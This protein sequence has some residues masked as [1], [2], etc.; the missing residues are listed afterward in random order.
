MLRVLL[1]TTL[2]SPFSLHMLL[3]TTFLLPFAGGV[4]SGRREMGMLFRHW[5]YMGTCFQAP[6][7]TPGQRQMETLSWADLMGCS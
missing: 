6:H 2:T 7:A 3:I 1:I 4:M 5:N